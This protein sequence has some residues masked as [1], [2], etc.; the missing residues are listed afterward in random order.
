MFSAVAFTDVLPGAKKMWYYNVGKKRNIL[1]PLGPTYRHAS[2]LIGAPSIN[3]S[4]R[5][6]KYT[7]LFFLIY[8]AGSE[9]LLVV[10]IRYTKIIQRRRGSDVRIMQNLMKVIQDFFV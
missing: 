5:F 2:S 9:K 4:L 6:V 3:E 1:I 10:S 8:A 7:S